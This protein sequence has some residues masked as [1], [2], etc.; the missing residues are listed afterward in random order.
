[1]FGV[2]A[3]RGLVH[4]KRLL[5]P[6]S[7]TGLRNA[8]DYQTQECLPSS[9][10][11]PGAKQQNE[12]QADERRSVQG[13]A[14]K[15]RVPT[16]S[17]TVHSEVQ[18]LHFRS[19]VVVAVRGVALCFRMSLVLSLAV[20]LVGR[21][22]SV[23]LIPHDFPQGNVTLPG[24]YHIFEF[25]ITGGKTN[26]VNISVANVGDAK[27]TCYP[28]YSQRD[29]HTCV[30]ALPVVGVRAGVNKTGSVSWN[31]KTTPARVSY[32]NSF[33]IHAQ[34]VDDATQTADAIFPLAAE[35]TEA[36]VYPVYKQIYAGQKQTIG[37]TVLG[38]ADYRCSWTVREPECTL[39]NPSFLQVE[40][41]RTSPGTCHVTG[42]SVHTV[43]SRAVAQIGFVPGL[44]SYT[45]TTQN[46]RPE[47]CEAD[48]DH[49]LKM[50]E[51]GPSHTYKDLAALPST[52]GGKQLIRL[53]NEAIGS[54]STSFHNNVQLIGSH[55]RMCGVRNASGVM[56]TIN[57]DTGATTASW[58]DP[59]GQAGSGDYGCVNVKSPGYD[60]H[61]VQTDILLQGFHVQNT[62]A[63]RTY[64]GSSGKTVTRGGG[65]EQIRF[66][67]GVGIT[68]SGVSVE[69]GDNGVWTMDNQGRGFGA[70]TR[71]LTIEYSN[72]YHNGKSGTDHQIY[73]QS[74]GQYIRYNLFNCMTPEAGGFQIKSRGSATVID[75]NF[76]ARCPGAGN[77]FWD[78]PEVQG[79]AEAAASYFPQATLDNQY[80]TK[81]PTVDLNYMEGLQSAYNR[82]R[83][84][85]NIAGSDGLFALHY[86][87]DHGGGY[88]ARS[89]RV[90]LIGNTIYQAAFGL[91]FFS[92]GNFYTDSFYQPSAIIRNNIWSIGDRSSDTD[93]DFA[94]AADAMDI[95]DFGVNIFAAN[96]VKIA[97]PLIGVDNANAGPRGFMHHRD[98]SLSGW[99]DVPMDLHMK[100]VAPGNFLSMRQR[101]F[102]SP[103][104]APPEAQGKA[105]KLFGEDAYDMQ[106]YQID[107]LTG[108]LKPRLAFTDLGAV[109]TSEPTS[110]QRELR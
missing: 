52:A 49:P 60:S 95:F 9:A 29:D 99:W 26:R 7:G 44:P 34:S 106:R 39:S 8:Q 59:P 33:S 96:T 28:D 63:G 104:A 58:A 94:V 18:F 61:P 21:A 47:P 75:T 68:V 70:L 69:D 55:I 19:P 35:T 62:Y 37:C 88:S 108:E 12:S 110:H 89:G 57:C 83:F 72:F 66:Q 22:Q 50:L 56:P 1:M 78:V 71:D 15:T 81:S 17:E 87:D 74:I 54:G 86:R 3:P 38:D 100:G 64:V 67:T 107:T 4:E 77:G 41:T 48:P 10:S 11:R 103:F 76:M 46:T 80:S 53:H 79:D 6:A 20:S 85:Y 73:I 30:N 27:L 102:S 40:V 84:Q 45:H 98:A 42:A 90:W 92:R 24:D 82:D 16:G 23:R 93:L 109:Q 97:K 43:S 101:V 91:T 36:H 5:Y 2:R 51:V 13:P 105:A 14:G 32:T 25:V 65:V 31:N